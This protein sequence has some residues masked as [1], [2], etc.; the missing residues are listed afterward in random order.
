MFYRLYID[1][2]VFIYIVNVLGL[3][4]LVR[5]VNSSELR[6]TTKKKPFQQETKQVMGPTRRQRLPVMR[7]KPP[8]FTAWLKV[9]LV[10]EFLGR[11]LP[12]IEPAP[13]VSSAATLIFWPRLMT[14]LPTVLTLSR[15]RSDTGMSPIYWTI[16]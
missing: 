8:A 9:R 16:L 6:F 3:S 15:S 11:E 7:F 4:F 13:T 5:Q 10:V 2:E 14:P 12:L 1:Q